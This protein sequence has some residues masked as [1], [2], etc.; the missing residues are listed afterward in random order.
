MSALL[1]YKQKFK[2]YICIHIETTK[3]FTPLPSFKYPLIIEGERISNKPS[4]YGLCIS[5]V[6]TCSNLIE[7][8]RLNNFCR[9]IFL[10][11]GFHIWKNWPIRSENLTLNGIV[12]LMK[13]YIYALKVKP[14]MFRCGMLAILPSSGR[15]VMVA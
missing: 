5:F 6:S 3:I 8:E 15:C 12:C 7:I 2:K 13:S 10:Y 1:D 4:L 14:S 9:F 11:L